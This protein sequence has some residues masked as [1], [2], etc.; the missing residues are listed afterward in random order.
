M[1]IGGGPDV[2]VIGNEDALIEAL[3]AGDVLVANV[4]GEFVVPFGCLG[5]FFAVFVCPR[6]KVGAVAAA[7]VVE[8][9]ETSD[10]IGSGCLVGVTHVC[11]TVGVVDGGCNVKAFFVGSGCFFIDYG[12]GG[13]GRRFFI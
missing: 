6:D 9:G 8:T 3:E 13:G 2:I 5:D 12:G 11:W 7:G 1:T 10:C 4:D